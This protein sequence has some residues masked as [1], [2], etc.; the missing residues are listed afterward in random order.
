MHRALVTAGIVLA[1]AGCE[2]ADRAVSPIEPPRTP[3]LAVA[4]MAVL[5]PTSSYRKAVT[6]AA[7]RAHQAAFQAIA[8]QYGGLRSSMNASHDATAEYVRAK[9][10]AAGYSVTV[11]PFQFVYAGDLTMPE[12]AR[13][14]PSPTSFI[15][16]VDFATMAYSGSGNVT[17]PLSAVDLQIPAAGTSSSG[18]E[19]ADFAGFPAG[20]IALMQR[21]TCNLRVKVV[22]AQA[23][24]ALA[25]IIMNEGNTAD[26]T[27][28]LSGTLSEPPVQ[29]PAVGTT[30]AVGTLLANGVL[31]GPTVSVVRVRADV[32]TGIA[33]SSNVIAE[34]RGGDPNDIVVVGANLDGRFGP[35]INATSG[36]AVML[37]LARAFT[38]QDRDSK[39]RLRFIWFGAYPEGIHG[40]TFYVAQLGTQDRARIRAMIDIQPVGS[41]NFGRFVLDGDQS[42]FTVP[43]PAD[44]A[45]DAASGGIEALFNEYFGASG[46]AVEPSGAAQGASLPFRNAG[47][48]IGGL[49]TGFS[50]AKTS[51]QAALFGGVA[52]AAFDPCVNL[53]CDTFNN[54]S[55]T[56]LDE[57][58]DAAAHVVLLL[59]RRNFAQKPL[60]GNPIN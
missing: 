22:N 51:Q 39:N 59:S 23:A 40:S 33:A 18:C 48:A 17:A 42:T 6:V 55:T 60:A 41:T 54:A 26:R 30:F 49:N 35:G 44:P 34:S 43:F 56:A 5:G 27:G 58:S 12:L 8:D 52:G 3:Q 7:I 37:E 10:V 57:M 38:A 13:V 15:P 45:A 1:I 50:T 24:G 36:S 11:Q 20:A 47:I 25:A 14:S 46:L 21:G 16:G 29:I 32:A 4:P 2:A 53:P 9:L 31:N 19:P 28:L